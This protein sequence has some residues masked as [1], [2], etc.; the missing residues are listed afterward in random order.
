[1][2]PIAAATPGKGSSTSVPSSAQT[3]QQIMPVSPIPLAL[4]TST[5][6]G[7][8]STPSTAPMSLS[9]SGIAPAGA[10]VGPSGKSSVL[11]APVGV[12]S[13]ANP[14]ASAAS[15]KIAPASITSV[16]PSGP[17]WTALS[18]TMIPQGFNGIIIPGILTLPSPT[19]GD[20]WKG[21][22][23]PG[24]L[25]IPS[26]SL[27]W[28]KS[29][30]MS[31]RNSGG[32]ASGGG[33]GSGGGS[34]LAGV[35][36][37]AKQAEDAVSKAASALN[38]L[39][40]ERSLDSCPISFPNRANA[41]AALASAAEDV[42]G[43]GAA[44][45]AALDESIEMQER[46]PP[47]A[48]SQIFDVQK[49][50]RG[51][52][53]KLKDVLQDV[54][55]CISKPEQCLQVVAKNKRAFAVGGPI[56]ALLAQ[57]GSARVAAL[58]RP[59]VPPMPT[60]STEARKKLDDQYF[61]V[62]VEGTTVAAYQKFIR[63]LPDRGSGVQ[64]HYD[65][66]RRYQTYL[67]RMT[68][69][70]AHA[71][72]GNRIV[73]M[74][75][76]NR[77]NVQKPLLSNYVNAERKN[78]AGPRPNR[79]IDGTRRVAR[80]PPKP[81]VKYSPFVLERRLHSDLHL[82]MLS[83]HPQA[84][85]SGLQYTMSDT[86]YDYL[87]EQSSGKGITVYIYDVGFDLTHE[88]FDRGS[89]LEPEVHV[90][91]KKKG[92]NRIQDGAWHGD[93][94]A[95]MAVGKSQGVASLANLVVVKAFDDDGLSPLDE[96]YDDWHWMMVD[97]RAKALEGK[98]VINYSLGWSY[99]SVFRNY[100]YVDYTRW[101][102]V[103]PENCDLFLPLLVDCWMAD[104]VTVVTAGNAGNLPVGQREIGRT[105]PARYANPHNPLIVVGSVDLDG[106]PSDFNSLVASWPG[107][108]GRDIQLTGEI[109]V[110][111]LGSQV[112]VVCPGRAD[113]YD[114]LNGT[115][116]AAPQIA[117][118]AAY[119]LGLPNSQWK[120]GNVSQLVK[121][122]ITDRK[123][124]FPSL[125]GDGIAYNSINQILMYC[126]P[127]SSLLPTRPPQRRWSVDL[128]H[129]SSYI[130]KFV[131]RRVKV[132][133][134]IIF[135][136]GHLKESKYSNEPI[137]SSMTRPAPAK[138]VIYKPDTSLPIS[139]KNCNSDP[140][141]KR[142]GSSFH[143]EE[144]ASFINNTCSSH[145]TLNIFDEMAAKSDQNA[146]LYLT[147]TVISGTFALKEKDCLN[148][149]YRAVLDCD[150]STDKKY[151]GDAQ[152]GD[153]HYYAFANV[154]EPSKDAH[155]PSAT[156]VAEPP[157]SKAPPNN[158]NRAPLSPPKNIVCYSGD[159]KHE[160]SSTHFEVTKMYDFISRACTDSK[161]Y[162]FEVFSITDN[163]QT[164]M[165]LMAAVAGKGE[166]KFVKEE[167][168]KFSGLH[169]GG[170]LTLDRISFSATASKVDN[171]AKDIECF[172]TKS[173]DNAPPF[174]HK[175]T[176]AAIEKAC[177]RA[178]KWNLKHTEYESGDPTKPLYTII[179][180]P[181]EGKKVEGF[182]RTFCVKGL[183]KAI[184]NCPNKNN[185]KEFVDKLRGGRC[186]IENI[187]FTVSPGCDGKCFG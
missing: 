85:V 187:K 2:I 74:I 159:K 52:F 43:Y 25:S 101:G 179:A 133:E 33:S 31:N 62:T 65:W 173:N 26:P 131:K 72:N 28:D 21:T 78:L 170:S 148:G 185:K 115:S 175:D 83:T 42:G 54:S 127:G 113:G 153:V 109:S 67:A 51:L 84:T 100:Q 117:G 39:K 46:F 15:A 61:I 181:V 102:L 171:K 139:H 154:S 174:H 144:M 163:G 13:T 177:L 68:E 120:S 94:V 35:L 49:S 104:I 47:A 169:Y 111:A 23:I 128:A 149:F 110:Y 22:I 41:V 161:D 89:A 82:R 152:I 11:A 16:A 105:S 64:R 116:F 178:K 134:A 166:R 91:P 17:Q 157:K 75:G 143:E 10:I 162:D 20:N 98:A 130:A 145:R 180:E 137:S 164:N 76:S 99:A 182:D 37:L 138:P 29:F 172:G 150:K 79:K 53:G 184:D 44:I 155:L 160:E 186:I 5:W 119:A 63:S 45:D 59:I 96:F 73:D 129:I 9:R 27:H 71:V 58:P 136:D 40:C 50:N 147:A 32:S 6:D 36:G 108:Y 69:L 81:G 125:D 86:Q 19:F 126:E 158:D 80:A 151:G 4:G 165:K 124:Q 60:N 18:S 107:A 132:Q 176:V 146:K 34:L 7:R 24:T 92:N 48:K 183:T 93:A 12:P 3:G 103:P 90:G 38:G 30:L 118:L 1:M 122:W 135:E 66:P 114:F 141:L 121:N 77:I 95:A 88:E 8:K 168:D 142:L 55:Q 123:R 97:V 106:W 56:L 70:E 87:H 140:K 156:P 57:Q 167:C 112:E 14:T